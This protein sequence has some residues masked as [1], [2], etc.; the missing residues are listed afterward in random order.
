MAGGVRLGVAAAV[1]VRDQ[2]LRRNYGRRRRTGGGGERKE[3][4]V[5]TRDTRGGGVA[6]AD[7]GG[8]RPPAVVAAE[9]APLG[10]ERFRG[11]A[12]FRPCPGERCGTGC[13]WS[14]SCCELAARCGGRASAAASACFLFRLD[15]TAAACALS[16]VA[17]PRAAGP[18]VGML[19]TGGNC[20]CGRERAP[21]FRFETGNE[22]CGDSA[23]LRKRWVSVGASPE[24]GCRMSTGSSTLEPFPVCSAV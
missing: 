12:G 23:L 21:Q 13:C 3:G 16:A 19:T 9:G 18:R 15:L 10:P 5:L 20:T 17:V 2:R 7:N 1:S 24:T 14:W 4:K 11:A 22:G 6:R 8:N